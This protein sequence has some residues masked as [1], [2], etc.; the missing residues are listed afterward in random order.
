MALFFI[1]QNVESESS[2]LNFTYITLL[3]GLL[4]FIVTCIR[5][6]IL[7]KNGA[8]R[9]GSKRDES[10][11]KLESGTKSYLP[12]ITTGSVGLVFILQY[13]VRTF[14]LADIELIIMMI[15]FFSLFYI[16]LFILPEQLVI[17]YC[18]HRFES[19]N[20]SENGKLKPMGRKAA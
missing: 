2:L 7:L 19:F 6:L 13:L 9:K 14:G 10:R 16:M 8:Y 17:L 12:I 4:I 5:F 1:G 15:L 3:L 20:Y 18:K 11:S